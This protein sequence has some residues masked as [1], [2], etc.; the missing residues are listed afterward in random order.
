MHDY[1][2][3]RYYKVW[4]FCYH[5]LYEGVRWKYDFNYELKEMIDRPVEDMEINPQ[6][7]VSTMLT[8]EL[9]GENV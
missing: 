2:E 4:N 7:L 5:T 1:D 9:G 8:R 3:F 6:N